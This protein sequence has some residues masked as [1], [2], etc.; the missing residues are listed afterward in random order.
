MRELSVTAKLS[1]QAVEDSKYW[2][3]STSGNVPFI[4]LAMCGEVGEVAN[5]VKKIERG[6]LKIEDAATRFDLAMEITDV[7]TY[8][9]VLAGTL[10]I[11]L[12]ESYKVKRQQNAERFGKKEP[13]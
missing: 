5:V 10:G 1:L 4:T 9:L 11:D 13:R 6:S 8:F 7:Y 12:E 2:F 3:P